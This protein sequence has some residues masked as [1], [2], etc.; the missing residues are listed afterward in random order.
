M[1]KGQVIKEI[2]SSWVLGAIASLTV[3]LFGGWSGTVIGWLLGT[4]LGFVACQG[5]RI[6]TPQIGARIGA[7]AGLILGIWLFV[8][9]IL[10]GF[11]VRPLS[12]QSSRSIVEILQFGFRAL[13]VTSVVAA[14]IAALQA[15][16]SPRRQQATLV[17]LA[18]ILIIFPFVDQV[19]R[20]SW[21]ATAIEIL[22]Y[23]I[24]ALGLNIPVGFAGL[25]DLGYAAFFAIGAYTTGL[26]SS[27]QLGIEWNFWLVLPIAA[28]V[29]A[30][31]GVVL[32]APTLR[33]RGDYLAIV[34]LGFGEIVPG[35]L[36]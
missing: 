15:L 16:P 21:I 10:E 36:S 32:G 27:S 23:V 18:F 24:L 25:L 3:I 1:T 20:T 7:N 14:L 5:K 31:A 2:K 30:L 29:A 34:T 35:Y 28:V 13:F 17:T 8:A 19:A 11:V 9:S 4:A 33:L 6:P 12:G 26:L 22:I